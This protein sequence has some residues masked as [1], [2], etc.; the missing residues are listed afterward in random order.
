VLDDDPYRPGDLVLHSVFG[1]GAVLAMRG[2]RE[3]RTILIEFEGHGA[4]ELQLS[5]AAAK[6]SRR[7]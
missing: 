7:A 1:N 2:P 5:F 4:K 6:L 3:G